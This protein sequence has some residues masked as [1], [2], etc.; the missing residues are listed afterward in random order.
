[1]TKILHYGFKFNSHKYSLTKGLYYT[2]SPIFEDTQKRILDGELTYN[3]LKNATF[4][5]EF[6]TVK[7]Y[8]SLVIKLLIPK[9]PAIT[10]ALIYKPGFDSNI[11]IT[12][13]DFTKKYAWVG[14]DDLRNSHI[15]L[16]T[17][18]NAR[19]LP[20]PKP[21]CLTQVNR[22]IDT[23][24]IHL[25]AWA[26]YIETQ[27]ELSKK[28]KY[29][30]LPDLVKTLTNS[31]YDFAHLATL[32]PKM[33]STLNPKTL[34]SIPCKTYVFLISGVQISLNYALDLSR[35]INF[36]LS[37]Y[38]PAKLNLIQFDLLADLFR[39]IKYNPDLK[40]KFKEL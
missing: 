25:R 8:E 9:K 23:Y 35:L 30:A 22:V 14:R 34:E 4:D 26:K 37:V 38:N 15:A 3:D 20:N 29:S 16:K 18:T 32:K 39:N 19:H 5:F 28:C 24:L 40:N 10:T 12:D 31:P 13:C 36:D 6:G 33:S 1:M 2:F 17:L 27:S 11:M 21:S 7:C